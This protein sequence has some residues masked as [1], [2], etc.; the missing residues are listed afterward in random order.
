MRIS[1]AILAGGKA[2]RLGGLAKGLLRGAQDTALIERLIGELAMAGV[3]EVI[4]SANDPRPYARFGKTLVA[5][6][7]PGAGPLGGIEA[8]LAH[9]A[10]RCAAVLFLPC[11]LP[12]L[13]AAEM[14]AILRAHRS[15]PDRIVMAVTKENEH[16]LCAVV[17]VGMLPAVSAAIGAGHYGVARLWHELAATSVSMDN[18]MGL[19][20]INTPEDLRRWRQ[21]AGPAPAS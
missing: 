8:S 6:L 3:H 19:L 17:P 9:L 13:S 10:H 5:E 1:A 12:N 2:S 18:S 21:A 4:L 7:H 16:P 20:N 11:D 15:M 14:K